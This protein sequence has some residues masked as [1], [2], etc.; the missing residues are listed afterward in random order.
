METKANYKKVGLFVIG[1]FAAFLVFVLWITNVGL[2]PRKKEY[3]I[4]FTGSVSGLNEGSSVNY[5]G[6]PIGTVNLI[7]IEEQNV[8]QIRVHVL[9]DPQ[10][11]IRETMVASLEMQG[12][13]GSAYVQ[14]N[15]GNQI[16]SPLSQEI[17]NDY[18]IIP[19]RPSLLEE[20]T[21]SAPKI[22]HKVNE[23][24]DSLV[25]WFSDE[26]QRSFGEILSNVHAITES[27][28]PNNKEG[29]ELMV[30]LHNAADNLNKTLQDLSGVS[31]EIQK[32]LGENRK[33][34]QEFSNSGLT[35]FTKF[36]QEGRDTLT[37]FRRIG[38]SIERSP[39]RFLHN[40]SSQGV[41]LK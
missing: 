40:D 36:L 37:T 17:G 5:R 9:I 11:T 3:D 28:D 7:E 19:S 38:E 41:R 24:T 15:G 21:S 6:V 1:F 20:V 29:H 30:S 25:K 31:H 23:I 34:L 39:T 35:A 8:E 18:P 14:I 32:I 33:G 10:I 27:F 22:I 16:D 13:T 2:G 26:N 12:I 4:Y